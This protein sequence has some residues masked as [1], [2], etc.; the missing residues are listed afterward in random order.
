MATALHLFFIGYFGD[1]DFE[2]D[3]YYHFIFSVS[4]F[5]DLPQ[6]LN[7]AAGVWP[8]PIFTLLMG[9]FIWLFQV[10]FLWIVK[11]INV[12][13]W[14][15]VN[16]VGYRLARL[17][18]LSATTSLI[19]TFLI[20]FSFLGFRAAIGTLTEPLF[21]L[22]ALAAILA[23]YERRFTTSCLLISLS[24]LARPEGLLLLPGWV[25]ILWVLC[26]RRRIDD[27]I[28]LGLFPLL[29]NF[30]GYQL[31]GDYTF[32]VSSGYPSGSPYGQGSWVHYPKGLLQY[33]PLL[34]PLAIAGGIM[35]LRQKHYYPLHIL[36]F[37]FFAFNIIAWRFGLFGTAG[38]LRYFV[39]VLPWLA[40]YAGA[41]IEAILAN[42][43]LKSLQKWAYI[44]LGGQIVFTIWILTSGTT[45]YFLHNTPK[46]DQA[47]VHA[48]IWIQQTYPTRYL[49]TAHPALLYYAR[50][51]FYSGSSSGDV[52]HLKPQAI[53]AVDQDFTHPEI[54]LRVQSFPKINSFA[55]SIYLYE[56]DL[57]AFKIP[58]DSPFG[59]DAIQPYLKTGWADIESWGVWAMGEIAEMQLYSPRPQPLNIS[60]SAFPHYI[61]HQQQT[62]TMFYND[63]PVGEYTFPLDNQEPQQILVHI[64]EN[65]ITGQV[66]LLKFVFTYAQSPASLGTGSD[67][68]ELAAGFL[69]IQITP[70]EQ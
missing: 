37:I 13:I 30:W 58:I 60:I 5:A 11:V 41:M 4:A 31:T 39:P 1:V 70:T 42:D 44:P 55:D 19:I 45:G 35:T 56:Y 49:H 48:G 52:A 54:M 34:F 18:Q 29:W 25:L 47:L 66:D 22:L 27:L 8:K 68:R 61:E 62:I 40:L 53:I 10:Q 51:D 2:P 24:G 65:L 3:S 7:W 57:T 21:A 23:L 14:L 46:I 59:D 64:P 32:I 63:T 26:G 17:L 12:L 50:R 16:I 33:E 6:S 43:A 67:A 69:N 9:F 38:L 15:G 20:Q 28:W 36:S